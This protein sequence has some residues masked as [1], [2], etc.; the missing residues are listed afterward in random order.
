MKKLFLLFS[1]SILL[2]S[3]IALHSGYLSGSAAL[4]SPN[5]TYIN[6]NVTGQSLVTYVLGFGGL[7][8][9][10]LVNNAIIDMKNKY[11][12][13]DNQAYANMSIN[14]KKAFWFG[15]IVN[16]HCDVNADI[17]EFQKLK[18]E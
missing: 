8:N 5:F 12:L 3:C 15:I 11:P 9:I 4:S 10:A 13:G 7:D 18:N 17:V 16:I 2:S 14:F 1:V 6:K